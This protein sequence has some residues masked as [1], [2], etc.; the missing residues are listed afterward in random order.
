MSLLSLSSLRCQ[1]GLQRW[2]LH[3]LR[4]F[5]FPGAAICGASQPWRGAG[6]WTNL[7]GPAL[8]PVGLQ[9]WRLHYSSSS[10]ERQSVVAAMAQSWEVTKLLGPALLPI[11]SRSSPSPW[12][13]PWHG[14]GR[15]LVPGEIYH[16][17]DH[18]RFCFP[19][20]ESELAVAVV[21]PAPI[22][23]PLPRS[24]W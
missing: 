4:V 19:P 11:P 16:L 24:L 12:T 14:R 18:A 1:L 21:A 3:P 13:H 9:R 5:F 15:E 2:R 8:L 6:T 22:L 17:V 23:P 10:P 20:L 7:L